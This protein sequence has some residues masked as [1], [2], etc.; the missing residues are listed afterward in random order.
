MQPPSMLKGTWINEMEQ[1]VM[2]AHDPN[3]TDTERI[4]HIVESKYAPEDLTEIVDKCKHLN[5]GEQR[6]GIR[7]S[8]KKVEAILCSMRTS[9]VKRRNPA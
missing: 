4:Q 3:T 9:R 6:L 5:Q 1:E 8:Q 2:F 7:P